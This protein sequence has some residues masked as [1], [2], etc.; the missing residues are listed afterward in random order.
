MVKPINDFH[1]EN[2]VV[3]KAQP[4]KNNKSGSILSIAGENIENEVVIFSPEK[5][6]E[7]HEEI[8][9]ENPATVSNKNIL[10]GLQN[11]TEKVPFVNEETIVEAVDG[12]RIPEHLDT[13]VDFQQ[14]VNETK[15]EVKQETPQERA[16]RIAQQAMFDAMRDGENQSQGIL[17]ESIENDPYIDPTVP[18]TNT[19]NRARVLSNITETDDFKPELKVATQTTVSS[20]LN[21]KILEEDTVDIEMVEKNDQ[22]KTETTKTTVVASSVEKSEQ[23]NDSKSLQ[24]EIHEALSAIV[25][26]VSIDAVPSSETNSL[27]ADVEGNDQNTTQE[28]PVVISD[29]VVEE[30]DSLIESDELQTEMI[31]NIRFDEPRS[32]ITVPLN[33]AE[34]IDPVINMYV[35]ES[36]EPQEIINKHLEKLADPNDYWHYLTYAR[37]S[38]LTNEQSYQAEA[39]KQAVDNKNTLSRT[40]RM[41]DKSY[42]N[43]LIKLDVN[44]YNDGDVIKGDQALKFVLSLN[45][46]VRRVYLYGSGFWVLI[47]PALLNELNNYYFQCQR[48]TYEFGHEFGQF[49]YIPFDVRLRKIG[50]ELFKNLII[51]SN[52]QNWNV[53]D[54]FEKSLSKT[55]YKVCLWAIASLMFQN[56]IDVDFV[57]HNDECRYVDRVKVDVSKMCINNYTRIGKEALMFVYSPEKK[58]P[59]MLKKYHEDI[60]KDRAVLELKDNWKAYVGVPSFFDDQADGE[61]YIAEMTSEIQITNEQNVAQ[62]ISARYYRAFSPFV[63]NVSYTD[64]NTG[65]VLIVKN[66]EAIP[67]VLNG[68]QLQSVGFA[69]A[70]L[71]FIKR[72]ETTYIGY[73]YNKCPKCG[74]V[75]TIAQNNIIPCD[76]QQS[77]FILT[78]MRLQQK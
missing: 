49:S 47:R 16:A 6:Q 44:K 1:I 25:D 38:Q 32:P 3:I 5:P 59:E 41:G 27:Y 74:H 9:V 30:S 12:L 22:P 63:I 26:E 33:T 31:D 54:T 13:T 21:D 23:K 53:G 28:V 75:P 76:V 15:Q 73:I 36:T 20:S 78:G 42:T 55:D 18:L 70:V 51:D 60:L 69:E 19:D 52:L 46:G 2:E 77:F 7:F 39:L 65:K 17:P 34:E 58:T 37:N 24:D 71:D 43:D 61:E 67:D 45:H 29:T 35:P 48:S 72:S 66:K 8:I 4:N 68:L 40:V 64:P 62:Y 57:C 11:D 14:F 50:I 10:T 56:G